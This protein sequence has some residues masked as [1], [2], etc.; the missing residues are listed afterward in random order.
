[1]VSFKFLA[2][3]LDWAVH[4]LFIQDSNTVI[5][6]ALGL[7]MA[8]NKWQYPWMKKRRALIRK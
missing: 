4:G 5:F 3:K 1:M 8:E 6:R 2:Q 7:M